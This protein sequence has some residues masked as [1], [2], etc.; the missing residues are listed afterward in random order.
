MPLDPQGFG[1][2]PAV[3]RESLQAV[4]QTATSG[5]SGSSFFVSPLWG[6]IRGILIGVGILA[7]MYGVYVW[8]MKEFGRGLDQH[9]ATNVGYPDV[10]DAFKRTASKDV[11]LERVHNDC[12]SRSDFIGRN[13]PRTMADVVSADGITIG[14]AVTYVSCLATENPARFCQPAHRS[15]L[16]AAVR[17]YYRLMA[18]M[19]D[20][21]VLMNA[22]PFAANRNALMGIP[23]REMLPTTQPPGAESDPRVIDALKA[24]I[25]NGYL[26]RRDLAA[27]SGGMPTD[28]ELA[29]RGVEPKRK[30]CG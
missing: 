20:E 3:T 4:Q 9:W 23:S 18:K 24:L 13:K 28:L 1:R 30:G 25:A 22:S 27:M 21:R 2:R 29:L 10:E 17:D 16:V 7:A 5:G 12:K 14:R 6:Q 19:R 8:M 15:H 11:E 26:T